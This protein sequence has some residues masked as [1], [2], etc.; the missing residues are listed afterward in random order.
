MAENDL[1][2]T[3]HNLEEVERSGN[4]HRQCRSHAAIAIADA[5]LASAMSRKDMANDR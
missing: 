3:P 4:C 5:A 2:M 1:P